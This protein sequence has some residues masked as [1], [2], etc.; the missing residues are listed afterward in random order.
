LQ[1]AQRTSEVAAE[2]QAV[3]IKLQAFFY[4]LFF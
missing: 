2:L 3:R 1:Q 4:F